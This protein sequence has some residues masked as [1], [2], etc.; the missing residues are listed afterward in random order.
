MV[1]RTVFA[2]RNVV[3]QTPVAPPVC[4]WVIE[5]AR[6][7]EYQAVL[8]MARGDRRMVAMSEFDVIAGATSKVTTRPLAAAVEG[9]I[10]IAGIPVADAHVEVKQ[11]GAPGWSWETRTDASGYYTVTV[12][13][14]QHMCVWVRLPESINTL[15]AG[16]C[17]EF[18]PG[19][20]RQDLDAPPGRVQVELIP[21]QGPI[22]ETPVLLVLDTPGHLTSIGVTVTGRTRRTFVGLAPGKQ[23]VTATTMDRGQV[24]DTAEVVFTRDE[25][26]RSVTL[27]VPYS[28]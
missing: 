18:G 14:S 15:T 25:P 22:L 19:T 28:R 12:M 26:V 11:N 27:L 8:Q 1:S 5:D 13:P 9:L 4:Q 7:G 3:F 2:G 23:M 20:N 21:R 6:P 16:R 10:S 24:F 17:R